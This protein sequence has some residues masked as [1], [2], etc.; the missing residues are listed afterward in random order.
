MA[1]ITVGTLA[2]L[3]NTELNSNNIY[4]GANSILLNSFN[5]GSADFDSDAQAFINAT[6][7]SGTNATAINNLVLALKAGNYWNSLYAIYPMIG[8][9]STTCKYNLKNPADTDAAYRLNFQGTW[10]FNSSGA[11][12]NGASGTYANT[13]FTPS[14]GF[15]TTNGHMSFYS[16]T[17]ETTGNP[18]DMG[19]E[20]NGGGGETLLT[21]NYSDN[22]RYVFYGSQGGGISKGTGSTTGFMILNK[23]TNTEG[24]YNGTRVINAGSTPSALTNLTLTLGGE[25][26]TSIGTYRPSTRGCSFATIGAT[27]SDPSGFTTVVNNYQTALGRNQF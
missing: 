13:Y 3:G 23:A 25:N 16:F 27:L 19:A 4:L 2:Y 11:K 7:I 14:V 6:G 21:L 22:N 10:T 1:I 17:N 20:T 8:G 9:T 18:V 5:T 12:P 24:W 15:T 26:S